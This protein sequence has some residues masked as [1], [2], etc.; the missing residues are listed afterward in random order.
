MRWL[1][2]QLLEGAS[3]SQDR[4]SLE[5][6]LKDIESVRGLAAEL[7][8]TEFALYCWAKVHDADFFNRAESHLIR[9][10]RLLFGSWK[11]L[12][13]EDLEMPPYDWNGLS[14]ARLRLH[15]SQTLPEP[16]TADNRNPNPALA[17]VVKHIAMP[18]TGPDIIV[19]TSTSMR[20]DDREH[21]YMITFPVEV[22]TELIKAFCDAFALCNG[23]GSFEFVGS[24][25]EVE[26]LVASRTYELEAFPSNCWSLNGSFG[27]T[28]L[29]L[30]RDS[31]LYPV[32]NIEVRRI[33]SVTAVIDS[34]Q[35]RVPVCRLSRKYLS[36][37]LMGSRTSPRVRGNYAS[38]LKWK[39]EYS[40]QI[41]FEQYADQDP[42]VKEY[43]AAV[44]PIVEQMGGT[45][46]PISFT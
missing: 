7:P 8:S 39:D 32:L 30:Q 44:R 46:K 24:S 41:G 13:M 5:A 12:L 21:T 35:N 33:P 6:H 15:L 18:L 14:S 36:W 2:V 31:S 11:M 9:S 29:A 28:P 23:V 26:S 3:S 10:A 19:K 16:V 22:A 4:F 34:L 40:F 38:F 37:K 27:R 20:G 17:S 1:L 25:E 43:L 45:L 42:A